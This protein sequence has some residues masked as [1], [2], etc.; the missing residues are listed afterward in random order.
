MKINSGNS[1]PLSQT[2][3]KK[4]QETQ[5]KLFE[6]IATG[7]KINSAKDDA[8]GL[9]LSNRMSSQISGLQQAYRNAND[10]VSYAQI[11]EGALQ[12]VTDVSFR[13]EELSIQAANGS[14]SGEQRQAIQAEVSQLQK[15]IGSVFEQTRFGDNAVFSGSTAFQV[16]SGSNETASINVQDQPSLAIDVTTQSGAQASIDAIAGFRQQIDR[17]RSDLGAFQN[18]LGS[19][20]ENISGQIES[21]SASRSRITDT[22]Y[23]KAVSDQIKADTQMDANLALQAQANV[24]NQSILNLL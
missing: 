23:A 19:V 10:G 20:M 1:L 8:A 14:L 16:G 5:E 3:L 24:S 18:R 21:S 4:S 15:Q 13:I 11:A 7:L 22:D 17:Q 6:Q 2:A 9:Q 12:N